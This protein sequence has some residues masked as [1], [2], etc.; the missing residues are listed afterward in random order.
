MGLVFSSN[1]VD[2]FYP[3]T[4]VYFLTGDNNHIY[5]L[6]QLNADEPQLQ[7]VSVIKLST[8]IADTVNVPVFLNAKNCCDDVSIKFWGFH[9]IAF[10]QSLR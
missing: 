10:Y 2:N 5:R 3:A 9:R 1:A 4:L 8:K 6:I 7:I